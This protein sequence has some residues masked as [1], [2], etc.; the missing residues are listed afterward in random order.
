[1]RFV[2]QILICLVALAAPLLPQLSQVSQAE[3]SGGIIPQALARRYGLERAW[4]TQIE[5]DRARSRIIYINQDGKSLFVQ[6]DAG[7][8]HVLDANTGSTLWSNQVGN[9]EYPSLAPA[10][11]KEF[12]AI[13]NG[14]TLYLLNRDNGQIKW[15]HKLGGG[16]GAGPAIS[17]D[18]V[19]VPLINGRVEAF[20][21]KKPNLPPWIYSSAGRAMVQPI[22]TGQNV[23]WPTSRGFLFVAQ[24]GEHPSIR[25]RMET[26]DEI[27]AKAVF[28]KPYLYISSLDGNVYAVNE[29]TGEQRWRFSAGDPIAEPA[30]VIDDRVYVPTDHAGMYCVDATTGRELWWAPRVERF[31]AASK[32]RVYAT[33]NLYQLYILDTKTGA[34]LATLP[35]YGMNMLVVNHTTDRIF[36]ASDSGL[37]QCLHDAS[38]EKPLFHNLN[39]AEK[40]KAAEAE[41]AA[42]VE[43]KPADDKPAADNGA[44]PFGPAPAKPAE[45]NGADPFGPAPAKPAEDKPAEDNGAD[46]FGAAPEKPAA[47]AQADPFGAAPTEKPADENDPFATE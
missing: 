45:D 31:L 14:S 17:E 6:T 12:V 18:H 8:L 46:P 4:F 40:A 29:I 11:N 13:V 32:D 41:A 35:I 38:L 37:I 19:F 10:A 21:I 47:D 5:L 42:A 30:S 16:P 24:T 7:V 9:A 36:L 15:T 43:A 2:K 39:E 20:D 25:F 22:Y 33:D 1:M 27:T 26:Q 28:R 3:T 34:K 23:A 44:D